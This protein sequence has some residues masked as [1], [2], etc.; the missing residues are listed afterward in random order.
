[1][2]EITGRTRILGILADPIYHVK[3]PQVMNTLL[4]RHNVDAVLVPFHVAPGQLRTLLDGLRTMQNF[5]GFIATVPHKPAM[6]ELCDETTPEA[7]Y[8]GAVNCVR[9]EAD[10]RMVGAMLDGIGFV[11]ALRTSGV[12]PKGLRA[13]LAGAGGAASAIA[14]AL[15]EA[16]VRELT[17][18]NRTRDKAEALAGRVRGIYPT[19]PVS[20]DADQVAAQDIIV[21]GTSLGMR[22]D[23]PLPL[24][25]AQIEPR[26]FVAEVIMDPEMTP[27]LKAAEA[28]GCRIQRGLPML[29]SQIVLMARH[30]GAL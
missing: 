6:L 19:L 24:D 21:N 1:M 7:R 2:Q 28:R 10:G 13:Y 15:A 12:E 16:G 25:V 8:I 30:M 23:D 14:F 27:L 11:E 18:A 20:T 3:T 17:I 9:R 4:A 5:G 22:P 26:Q 29:E